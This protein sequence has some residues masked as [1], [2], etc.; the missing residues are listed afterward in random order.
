MIAY[1]FF[2]PII[3]PSKSAN[4]QGFMMKEQQSYIYIAATLDT[5]AIETYYVSQLIKKLA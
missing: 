3:L 1:F 4:N 5:K 2:A